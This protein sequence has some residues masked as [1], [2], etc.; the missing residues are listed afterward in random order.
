MEDKEIWQMSLILFELD[1]FT[2]RDIVGTTVKA[3][4]SVWELDGCNAQILTS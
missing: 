1:P 3:W 2:R 4:I